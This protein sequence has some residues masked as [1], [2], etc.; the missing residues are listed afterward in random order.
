MLAFKDVQFKL[1]VELEDGGE[2]LFKPMRFPRTQETLP[3]HFY[4]TDFERHNAEIA[5]FHLG[6]VHHIFSQFL[7]LRIYKKIP[8]LCSPKVLKC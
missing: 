1:I 4:F 6:Q 8:Q 5:A 3:D 2:A 7:N